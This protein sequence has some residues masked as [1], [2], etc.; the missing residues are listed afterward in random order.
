MTR[1]KRLLVTL[2]PVLLLGGIALL[3]AA[4]APATQPGG[5]PGV[6]PTPSQAPLHP[7]SL[8]SNPVD[9]LAWLFNPI[10]QTLFVVLVFFRELTGSILL[11]IL[12]LTILLRVLVIPLYRRQLVSSRQM[13]L[14]QPEIKELQRKYKGDRMKAQTAVQEFY[15]QRG[16]N[17]AGGCLPTL[18]TMGL[19]IPMYSVFSQGL[20]NFDP[21]AMWHVF[22]VNLFPGISCA[23]APA[24][25]PVTH[26]V[27][28]ACLHPIEFGINWGIPEPDTTGLKLAGFGISILAVL[29]SLVQL[30]ASRM[31]VP[32]H[33]PRTA[34][35]Q[36]VKVQ[37]QMAYFLPLIS[38]MYGGFL[39]AGLFLYWIAS[40]VIQI[41]QQFLLIGWGGMFPLFGWYPEFARNH[42]P[43][44]PVH[45]PTPKPATPG[46]H[47]SAAE[48]AKAVD[49]DLSARSTIRPNRSRSG[50]RGRRR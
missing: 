33:D 9:L 17:P 23:T 31:T 29:S 36:N 34:D 45:I 43:R 35:D 48:R 20:T 3:V 22:G 41:V 8:G 4:C 5:S 21:S 7:A 19:L 49:R 11:A 2:A 47:S 30:V 10:F 16:I 15:K 12:L 26:H 46:E 1:L 44:F 38:I 37:R 50:R 32:P 40:T 24:F 39:P 25:D 13:Q 6:T 28:N 18:L 27:T 14:L 42:T